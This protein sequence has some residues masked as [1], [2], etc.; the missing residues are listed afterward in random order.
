MKMSS[1][2]PPEI[3]NN[4]PEQPLGISDRYSVP[5]ELRDEMVGPSRELRPQWKQCISMLDELGPAKLERCRESARRTIHEN[6]VTHNVY[7]DP[8][9]LDRPWD[10]DLI[11]LLIA[12]DEWSAVSEGL[13]QRAK[14]LDL[15]LADFYGPRRA[16]LDG[17]LP[18]ELVFGNAA[19]LRACHGVP[20]PGNRRLHLYAADLVRTQQGDF[21]VLS[22][23]TQAPSGTG[24]LLENRIAV[25]R[26][27]PEIYKAC[28]VERLAPFFVALRES[29][30]RSSPREN[31]RIVLL[32]PG[33][34]NETY[35]E[36]AYLAQYLGYSL[37]Q[38]KDLTVRDEMVYLKTVGGLQRVDVILRR[39]DDDY[40]DNL[41]LFG[42][43]FLGVPGLLQAVRQGNVAVANSLGTGVLQAPGFLPFLPA[44]CRE[45][46][47][48]ELK[49]PSVPTWWCGQRKEMQYVLEHLPELVIKSAF[50]TRGA[51]P[52][53]GYEMPEK[54]LMDLADAIK[55]HP[56]QYVAQLPA[57]SCTTPAFS[58]HEVQPRRFVLRS[59]L[60]SSDDSYVIMNGGLT[61]I[62]P[63]VDSVLVS[64]QRGG[65]SKDT[66][67]LSDAPVSPITLL[68]NGSQPVPFSLGTGDLP[69]MIA[70]NLY[71]LGRYVERTEGKV[72]LA[73][74][75]LRRHVDGSGREDSH[76]A[77]ILA[78][79]CQPDGNFSDGPEFV[80]GLVQYVRDEEKGGLGVRDAFLQIQSL[81]RVL[82]DRFPA[83]AYRVL[84][85]GYQNLFDRASDEDRSPEQA[86]RLL[87]G[88]VTGLAAFCGLATDS[89][90]GSQAWRFYD[91][92]RRLE[93]AILTL[94][95][96]RNIIQHPDD[97]RALLEAVLEITE[98]TFPYRRR[99]L[100]RLERLAALDLLL[101]EENN[102]RSVAFQLAAVAEHLNALPRGS[103][104]PDLHD[105]RDQQLL[106]AV[107]ALIREEEAAMRQNPAARQHEALAQFLSD[108][109]DHVRKL[110]DAIAHV[111]FSHVIVSLSRG[112]NFREPMN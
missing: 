41:E 31:P 86:M 36:H 46:L 32:T 76:A 77:K 70:D 38:G 14:L 63:S 44:L 59:Y 80:R 50:P 21:Q 25:S 90:M 64:L 89:M 17:L 78:T 79:W 96:L 61:R 11:P 30:L 85:E 103:E 5:S 51:D 7:G 40:C 92:G 19:F 57:M 102:P 4:D 107:R 105:N 18:P 99:Y 88:V 37:V 53:F 95:L 62:T 94:E 104:S 87:D 48:E 24:Y 28:N 29:L 55:L 72:H 9:G 52:V 100:T 49:L 91:M 8:N 81:T 22:D 84:Q 6:G 3:S 110:S 43:S 15:L 67:I 66:W 23:R 83:D 112:A 35:F 2:T 75:A 60:V 47:G 45:F 93:R 69:S 10:L 74:T 26:S 20:V 97:D 33:P 54:Q 68:A 98:C 111:Y 82:R 73:R 27:I 108:V 71:W 39:V 12:P 58:E 106:V 56:E 101:V 42:D 34:Y 65:G 109:L 1:T 13:I 16:I